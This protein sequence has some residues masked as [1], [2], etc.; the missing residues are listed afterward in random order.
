ML[1]YDPSVEVINRQH[2]E[3]LAFEKLSCEEKLALTR[4]PEEQ[5]VP[6]LVLPMELADERETLLDADGKCFEMYCP[7]PNCRIMQYYEGNDSC[8]NCGGTQRFINNNLDGK[9]VNDG[10]GE[11]L[12]TLKHWY[13]ELLDQDTVFVHCGQLGEDEIDPVEP[14]GWLKHQGLLDK[15][16]V[17]RIFK[18]AKTKVF[19]NMFRAGL[20][21]NVFTPDREIKASRY[22]RGDPD[23]SEPMIN[24]FG[25]PIEVCQKNCKQ[26]HYHN[27]PILCEVDNV[28]PTE[29]WV[30][31]DKAI[32]N[33]NKKRERQEQRITKDTLKW[34]I[35]YTR[36][37]CGEENL[38]KFDFNKLS[39]QDGREFTWAMNV[40]GNPKA[41]PTEALIRLQRK[42]AIS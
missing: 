10:E 19:G 21:D 1:E 7:N 12:E 34:V 35:I 16:G 39:E 11:K 17:A 18:K 42:C 27:F 22:V 29:Y 38:K 20:V 30:A 33:A 25:E 31:R 14:A 26:K 40:K 6:E 28:I 32:E 5:I 13:L 4:E 9:T 3:Y 2:K 41:E 24:E 37:F 36:K 8:W 23:S 15:K